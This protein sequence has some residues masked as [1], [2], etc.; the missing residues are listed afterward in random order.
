M[1]AL[2]IK[3]GRGKEELHKKFA[4]IEDA[5]IYLEKLYNSYSCERGSYLGT[6]NAKIVLNNEPILYITIS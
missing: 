3:V 6:N 1:F 2:M 5:Q 4:S